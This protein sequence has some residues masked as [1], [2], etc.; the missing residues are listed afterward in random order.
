[1]TDYPITA[2]DRRIQYTAA[3]GET[4]LPFDFPIFA[5]AE[6]TVYRTRSG[7]LSTLVLN[8]DYTVSGLDQAAGGTVTLATGATAGD[9][10]T[11]VGSQP[12]ERSTDFSEGGD[13]R[14]ETINRELDRLVVM[15]QEAATA[16]T[17]TIGLAP[18]DAADSLALPSATARAG[19]YLAFDSE[20]NPIASPGTSGGVAVSAFMATVLDDTTAAAARSTLGA[21]DSADIAAV[22]NYLNYL[23]GVR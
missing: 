7:T 2:N 11:L 17:R 13:F 3:G 23:N 16:R 12:I 14:A 10:L 9:V 8:S 19:N 18:D 20:G 1:M 6:I 21:A 22:S 5:E 4:A 15:Q